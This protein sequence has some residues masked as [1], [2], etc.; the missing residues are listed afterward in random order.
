MAARTV[1]QLLTAAA[2]ELEVIPSGGSLSTAE[3]AS[4]LDRFN[5]LVDATNSRRGLIYAERVDTLALVDGTQNYTIG[6][7]PAGVATANYAI[8]RPSRVTRANLFI[9]DDVPTPLAIYTTQEWAD[10]PF[11]SASGPP[12]GVY[13]DAAFSSGRATLHFDRIPDQ[14]YDWEMYS[15]QQNGQA[16]SVSTAIDYPPGYADYWLY[17]MAVKLAPMF[18]R[19]VSPDLR[20]ALRE[21]RARLIAINSRSPLMRPDPSFQSGHDRYYNWRTGLEE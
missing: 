5:R 17:S 9:A 14:A 4:G 8:A 10:L 13:Y 7:D 19:T 6:I 21:A 12:Q 11:R 2:E 16:T 20:E 15:W 1:L 18:G 3:Q